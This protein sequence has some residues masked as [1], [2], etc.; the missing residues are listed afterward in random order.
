MKMKGAAAAGRGRGT[1]RRELI[2]S[3]AAHP[4]RPAS[5]PSELGA[6]PAARAGSAGPRL[7][8]GD[9]GRSAMGALPEGPEA[10]C[11]LPTA[12]LRAPPT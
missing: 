8:A 2:A 5:G 6:G 11:C 7:P 12:K 9:P 4:P 1:C 3:G 10:D